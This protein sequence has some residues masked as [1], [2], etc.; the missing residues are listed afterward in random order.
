MS[1]RAAA[2]LS[3]AALLAAALT[4]SGARIAASQGTTITAM[5]TSE[6]VPLREPWDGF[7]DRLPMIDIPLSAQQVTPPMGGRRW[8]LTAGA[9]Q[10]SNRIYVVTEWADASPDRSVGSSQDFTDAVAVQFPAIAASTVPALCMGDPTA[11]V[12]MWQWRAAWQADVH[13]GFQGGVKSRYPNT[14]VDMYPSHDEEVFYPG[15]FAGNPFSEV[16]RA[17]AVDNLVAGGFGSLTA[18]PSSSVQGWGAWRDGTWRVVFARTLS[19]G[20]EGNVELHTPDITD[21]AFA[22]W[23]GAAEERN[24]MKSVANFV[25]LNLVTSEL[26]EKAGWPFWPAPY[27]AFIAVWVGLVWMLAG[28]EARRAER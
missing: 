28:R 1:R 21:V 23:D 13:C 19:V 25:K 15:R 18:D 9:V 20:R 27:F 4:V 17:S 24:G 7:W 14:A 6:S 12:N 26:E 5:R 8:T 2:V 3:L 22:V 11:S 16:H 10:D